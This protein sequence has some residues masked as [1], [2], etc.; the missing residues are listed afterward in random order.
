[1]KE[2]LRNGS[3]SKATQPWDRGI[4]HLVH[5]LSVGCGLCGLFFLIEYSDI[6]GQIYK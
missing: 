6:S 5:L 2:R 4:S 1:M 3:S